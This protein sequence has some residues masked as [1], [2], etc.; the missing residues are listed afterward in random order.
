MER[1]LLESNLRAEEEQ[2][3]SH[4]DHSA[5]KTH[6]TPA[7]VFKHCSVCLSGLTCPPMAW[8]FG[9]LSNQWQMVGGAVGIES[10]SRWAF[11]FLASTVSH[12]ISQKNHSLYFLVTTFLDESECFLPGDIG[13]F[14]LLCDSNVQATSSHDLQSHFLPHFTPLLPHAAKFSLKWQTQ[15]EDF[16]QGWTG[17]RAYRAFSR[18]ADAL[19]GPTDFFFFLPRTISRNNE[20]SVAHWFVSCIDSVNHPITMRYR[21]SYEVF[22]SA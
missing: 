13:Q 17:N 21:R 12:S 22:C 6:S 9:C 7:G 4:S 1:F 20:Q 5:W 10:L 18:W 3:F 2:V 19:K 14:L 16:Q 8:G 15:L 11:E